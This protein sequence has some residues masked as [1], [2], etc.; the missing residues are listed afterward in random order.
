MPQDIRELL[1]NHHKYVHKGA[2][3]PGH[4]ARFM[5]MLDEALPQSADNKKNTLF[6][7][8]FKSIAAVSLAVLGMVSFLTFQTIYNNVNTKVLVSN[9]KNVSE[10]ETVT[11]PKQT[12]TLAKISPEYQKVENYFLTS[13]KLQMD[14]IQV[15]DNNRDLVQSFIQRLSKL[16]DEYQILN[17]ELSEVGINAQII[18]AMTQ[19]LQ[20]RVTLLT[21]LKQR[22]KELDRSNEHDN[23][24][25]IHT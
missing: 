18:E 16:D 10:G 7:N 3:S 13:I 23:F 14:S 22:I 17:Q 8:K 20:M 9:N 1:R 21:N 25:E 11:L 5:E 4:E 19:N 12:S 15:N 24:K 6:T 2:I